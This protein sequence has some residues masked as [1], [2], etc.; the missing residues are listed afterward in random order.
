M[1][2]YFSRHDETIPLFLAPSDF[3]VVIGIFVSF[4]FDRIAALTLWILS[5]YPIEEFLADFIS[6]YF[7]LP[8]VNAFSLKDQWNRE[9]QHLIMTELVI[10]FSLILYGYP[11]H[12][13][14][15]YLID[16]MS[17]NLEKNIHIK[18]PK[19]FSW[20]TLLHRPLLTSHEGEFQGFIFLF[21]FLLCSFF[22]QTNKNAFKKVIQKNI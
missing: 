6:L 14:K 5:H 20:F 8:H 16:F 21:L 13:Y 1:I 7:L 22:P 15:V 9:K 12:T 3:M 10:G 4:S 19:K 2:F 11:F 18:E 17:L